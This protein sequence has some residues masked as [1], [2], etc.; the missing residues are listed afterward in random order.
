MYKLELENLSLIAFQRNIDI[1]IH[2]RVPLMKDYLKLEMTFD[3]RQ[4]FINFV[5]FVKVHLILLI[6]FTDRCKEV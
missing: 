2:E 4:H 6:A 1:D 5:N 3:D